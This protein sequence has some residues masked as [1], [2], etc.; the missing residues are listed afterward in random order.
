MIFYHGDL[1][2]VVEMGNVG[3][4]MTPG[5]DAEGAILDALE[6]VEGRITQVRRPDR[7]PVVN[8]RFDVRFVHL[9]E[10]LFLAA[11]SGASKGVESLHFTAGFLYYVHCVRVEVEVGIKAD[12]E[13][14]GFLV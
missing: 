7:R 13:D 3:V 14:F 6:A 11:P 9:Q 2:F 12:A 1:C 10:R 5:G 8:R 4:G